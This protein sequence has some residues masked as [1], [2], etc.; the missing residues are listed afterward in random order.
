MASFSR[1][2]TN[3][4]MGFF[5]ANTSPGNYI[6]LKVQAGEVDRDLTAD[7]YGGAYPRTE[8]LV[9]RFTPIQFAELMTNM[10]MGDGVPC[11]IEKVM[12]E[13]VAPLEKYDN[14]A[15]VIEKTFAKHMAGIARGIEVD[16]KRIDQLLAKT[17][18][19][20]KAE[21][22]ELSNLIKSPLQEI[23][24]NIP[25]YMQC[26]NEGAEKIATEV[27]TNLE[28]SIMHKVISAG[29]D[30]LGIKKEDFLGIE[31]NKNEEV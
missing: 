16:Q 18:P 11:T 27:M 14:R 8:Y 1:I 30:A 21:K 5:G 24:S 13:M 12:G 25:Y 4:K 22:E 20:N 28:A 15:V 19:L 9:A 3:Q 23:A 6:E 7:Y 31:N 29:L 26:F 17:S 2:S 10:N